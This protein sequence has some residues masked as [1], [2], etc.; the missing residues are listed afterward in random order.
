MLAIYFLF[1]SKKTNDYNLLINDKNIDEK[2]KSELLNSFILTQNYLLLGLFGITTIGTIV[3]ANEKYNQYGGNFNL[4]K[5][6]FD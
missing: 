2:V 3:Y 1:E 6:V 5:F 4:K